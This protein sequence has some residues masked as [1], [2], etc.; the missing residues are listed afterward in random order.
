VGAIFADTGGCGT[1]VGGGRPIYAGGAEYYH[2]RRPEEP[3]NSQRPRVRST[4]QWWTRRVGAQAGQM[5]EVCYAWPLCPALP[6]V[7]VF[8]TLMLGT[9]PSIGRT[10]PRMRVRACS[11]V[12]PLTS[13]PCRCYDTGTLLRTTRLLMLPLRIR[14]CCEVHVT[15]NT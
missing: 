13:F 4:C 7:C 15:N 3:P 6:C 9:V 5:L 8:I 14:I 12:R 11:V 1:S 2:A 10:A